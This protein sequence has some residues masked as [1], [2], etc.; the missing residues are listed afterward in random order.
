MMDYDPEARRDTPLALKLKERIRRE[1]PIT[2]AQY[3]D[4]CLQDPDYG[5]YVKQPAIGA[6]A[7][8]VTAPEI[9]QVFGEL[10]GL[11]CAVVWQQMGCPTPFDLVEYGPGRGTM[12]ADALRALAKAPDCLA[13]ARVKL[14][15]VSP[16]LRKIQQ[17]TLR[18]APGDITWHAALHGAAEPR[19]AIVLANEVIDAQ[20]VEQRVDSNGTLHGRCLVL[21][22]NGMLQFCVRSPEGMMPD[23]P[24]DLSE[25]RELHSLIS[26]D[27][28]GLPAVAALIFDYGHLRSVAGDTLQ[29][30]RSHRFE[31]PL[32]SPGEADLTAQVD[33]E[34]LAG[35]CR[36]AGFAID[37]PITQGEFLA[38][39]GIAERASRLMTA[40]PQR[41][42]EIEA[43]VARLMSPTGM[44]TLFKAI[45]LRSPDLPP[46]PGFPGPRS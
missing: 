38:A 17:T 36:N 41:A 6:K 10:I 3:M 9:S 5:Y 20:P 24:D 35:Q 27:L 45:G 43:G 34:H 31:H 22:G 46:L 42:G 18:S 37:G 16:A 1:G 4:A 30:V 32:T 21:D 39:L 19:R 7:D 13:A 29:A 14:V 28:A 8:F 44:G 33:F 12:M 15:E 11:W 40:N 25:V 23:Q 2:V 26:H